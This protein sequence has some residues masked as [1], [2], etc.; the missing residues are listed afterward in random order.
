MLH[1]IDAL[2]NEIEE[3]YAFGDMMLDAL[4]I[5]ETCG[6]DVE[7]L[8]NDLTELT[9]IIQEREDDLYFMSL[10]YAVAA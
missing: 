1:I 5:T 9:L 6:G 8:I 3:L 4:R 7:L 2:E 10:P